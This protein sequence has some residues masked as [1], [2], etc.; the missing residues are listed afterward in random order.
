MMGTRPEP[1][2]HSLL[3][4]DPNL[5]SGSD[6]TANGSKITAHVLGINAVGMMWGR[7][8]RTRRVAPTAA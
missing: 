5:R 6:N 7:R 2:W 4:K 3:A 8:T 1:A